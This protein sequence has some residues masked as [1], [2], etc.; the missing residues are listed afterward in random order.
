MIEVVLQH[1]SNI[2]YEY[3]KISI[4]N[5]FLSFGYRVEKLETLLDF[6]SIQ[7]SDRVANVKSPYQ[8][9]IACMVEKMRSPRLHNGG[10]RTTWL[11]AL[12]CLVGS[13]GLFG[14]DSWTTW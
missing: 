2:I 9:F 5:V 14:G 6:T 1:Y 13:T 7:D 12:D 4:Q 11:E 10:C 8:L 3:L